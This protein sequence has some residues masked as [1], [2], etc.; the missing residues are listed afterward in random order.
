[1]LIG[2]KDIK[3]IDDE[4]LLKYFKKE[5]RFRLYKEFIEKKLK[6]TRE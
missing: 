4:I 2:K 6:S 3:L 1:M 5:N